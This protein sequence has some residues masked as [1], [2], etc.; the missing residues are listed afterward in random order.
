MTCCWCYGM[1]VIGGFLTCVR[2]RGVQF[3]DEGENTSP[4]DFV[5][6][7]NGRAVSVQ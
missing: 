2:E 4:L 5:V 6:L 3:S 1:S 7:D